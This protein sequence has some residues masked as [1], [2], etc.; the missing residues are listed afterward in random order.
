MTH[1]AVAK[2]ILEAR[3]HV[4]GLAERLG[5][6]FMLGD[7]SLEILH[8]RIDVMEIILDFPGAVRA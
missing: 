5:N 4:I 1:A 6:K 3:D 7:Y 8:C 2:A